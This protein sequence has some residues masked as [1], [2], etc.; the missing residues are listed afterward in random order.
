MAYSWT[1]WQWAGCIGHGMKEKQLKDL[2]PESLG[3]KN[4]DRP[5]EEGLECEDLFMSCSCPLRSIFLKN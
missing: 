4:T 2:E 1:I 5:M 3:K